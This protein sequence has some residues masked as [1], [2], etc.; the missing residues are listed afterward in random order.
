VR[1]WFQIAGQ[2]R[3][4]PAE[5]QRSIACR[6]GARR[7]VELP[8]PSHAVAVSHPGE[9]ARLARAAVAAVP[10]G[11]DPRK[12]TEMSVHTKSFTKPLERRRA[13]NRSMR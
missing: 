12:E 11:A 1:S 3:N 6:A 13:T 9:T 2:D 10:V 8:T 5:L 7:T 4:I